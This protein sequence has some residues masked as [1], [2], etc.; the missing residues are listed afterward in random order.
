MT[1]KQTKDPYLL[2]SQEYTEYENKKL[3]NT[4]SG[5][6]CP[7]RNFKQPCK[8]CDIVQKL[9]NT[10]SKSNEDIARQKMAKCNFYLNVVFPEKQNEVKLLEIGKKAGSQIIEGIK[11]KGWKDIAHP[12]AGKGRLMQITK[13]KDGEFNQYTATPDLEKADWDVS[14]EVLDSRYNLNNIVDILKEG[15]VEIFKIS[16]IKQDDTLSFRILPPVSNGED[17]GYIMAVVWRHWGGVTQAEVEGDADIDLS[18]PDLDT[19]K[20]TLFEPEQEESSEKKGKPDC[21]GLN[22]CYEE[23]HPDC[24][25]CS[26]YKE[27]AREIMKQ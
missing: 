7:K 20:S 26:S 15:E 12:A 1:K 13:S 2:D 24:V 19:E 25:S 17:K 5:V 16:S 22:S 23:G 21:F 10:G 3:K 11:Q 18:M 9:F 8:V 27:C 14:K 4:G 6:F